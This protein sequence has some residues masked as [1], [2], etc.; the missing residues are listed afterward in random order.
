MTPTE[1]QTDIIDIANDRAQLNVDTT[2]SL[3]QSRVKEI[4]T[5]KVCLQCEKSTVGWHR[6]C[7]NFCRD[8]WQQFN[9][10]A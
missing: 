9:P 10:E 7:D 1:K 8:D 3:I 4:A 2:I 5:S 6:F